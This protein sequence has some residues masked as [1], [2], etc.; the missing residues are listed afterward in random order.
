VQGVLGGF[1]ATPH[2]EERLSTKPDLALLTV[3]M[4]D[5]VAALRENAALLDGVPIVVLQNGLRGEE[6]AASVVHAEQLVSGVVA[7]HAEYLVPGH[8]VLMQSEGLSIGRPSGENDE[9][10]ERVRAV[11]DKA[12][13]TSVTAN[14]RG[15]RWTKLIVNLANV[16]PALCDATLRQ[17]YK[18]PSLRALAV[19]LMHEGIVV[20]ER[21]GVRLESIPGTSVPLVSL[22]ASLPA[23]LAG[24]V[25]A[26][27]A[28]GVATNSKGSTWQSMVRGRPTEV[29][30]LNGEIVMLG[31]TLQVPTPANAFVVALMERVTSER[32]HLT[33]REIDEAWRESTSRQAALDTSDRDADV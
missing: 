13:P 18:D 12:I 20:A 14:I 10:V 15:A 25:L 4:H 9:V 23:A 5:I 1:R 21:A 19:R 30:Y 7:L 32:R 2:A 24:A 6:L 31:K 27:E 17:V 26:G 33:R 11:L 29:E 3:K 8:V 28:Q 16:L 22:I